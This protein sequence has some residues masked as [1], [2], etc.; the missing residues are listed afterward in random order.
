MKNETY[1]D[2][3]NAAIQK[4]K[5]E[6]YD[7]AALY[8]GKARNVATSFNTQAWSEYR[9]EHNEK[10]YSLHTSYSSATRVLKENRKIAAINKRTAEVLESHL[11]NHAGANKWKQRLQQSEVNND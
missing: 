6:K 11:E 4:E 3:A 1:L 10:R 2:F 9:Q 8:W 7:L 5:E